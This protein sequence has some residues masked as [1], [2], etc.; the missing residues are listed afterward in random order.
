VAPDQVEKHFT[1]AVRGLVPRGSRQPSGMVRDNSSLSAARCLELFDAQLASRH[2][3]LAARLLQAE[4]AG[5][6][7]IGSSGHE[8]NAGLAAALRLTDPALLHYRSGAFYLVRAGQASPP[9][10]GVNDVLLGLVAAAAEPISGGRHKV[11]GHPQ[12]NV[13]PQT[14]TIASHLPRAVGV[15]FA[16]ARAAKLGMTTRWP[17]DAIVVCSF[18]DASANHCTATGAVNTAAYC[19]Y[20]GLPLPLLLVC[21]DNG[22]GISVRTPPG[23]IEA[24]QSGRPCVKYFHA[25]GADLAA[26]YDTAVRAAAWVRERREPAFLHLQ[27]VRFGGHAGSDVESSYRVASEIAADLG[28]DPLLGTAQLLVVG[29]VLAPAEILAR[30]EAARER[31]LALAADVA[32]APRLDSA[33]QVMAPLA[34]R[35]PDAV[36]ADAVRAARPAAARSSGGGPRTR[37]RSPWPRRS[38]GRWL[39]PSP[40]G[41]R[42][43]YS[44]R[45]WPARAASTG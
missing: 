29:G 26:V 31:V 38:T 39:T 7:T 44:G 14:S 13:I 45:T 11:F 30:Y 22:L 10:D 12:L 16:L 5:F 23:W 15:A 32:G 18:G 1:A 19:S 36:A 41:R 6:Y 37:G 21:E 3:D 40:S 20:Q 2:L 8:G 25:D 43:W 17:D 35:R 4:G 9:R 28:R 34:P 42:C 27:M 33:A 24:T